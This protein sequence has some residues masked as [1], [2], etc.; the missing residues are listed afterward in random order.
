MI[1]DWLWKIRSRILG[2]SVDDGT[3]YKEKEKQVGGEWDKGKEWDEIRE[4]SG[5]FRFVLEFV[6]PM[7]YLEILLSNAFWCPKQISNLV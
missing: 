4:E 6:M 1:K 3:I 2:E 7:G 5:E